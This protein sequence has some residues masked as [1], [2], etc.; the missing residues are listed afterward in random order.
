[1][2]VLTECL[3]LSFFALAFVSSISER[4]SIILSKRALESLHAI[5]LLI[6][7]PA[8]TLLPC[9]VF[10]IAFTFWTDH[11]VFSGI[12]LD[13]L[14]PR[15]AFLHSLGFHDPSP[16]FL[17]PCGYELFTQPFYSPGV[18]SIIAYHLKLFVWYM[19]NKPCH[20]F[21][22]GYRLLFLYSIRLILV[23]KSCPSYASIRLHC[24]GRSTNITANVTQL[25]P[26]IPFLFR[27]YT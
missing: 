6:C 21:L 19:S 22:D 4:S 10:I 20:K 2:F 1:M 23:T 7:H 14:I 18:D 25:R 3:L 26:Y 11:R 5:S 8:D 24:Y 16:R 12:L 17:L 15:S 9:V 13:L 27:A